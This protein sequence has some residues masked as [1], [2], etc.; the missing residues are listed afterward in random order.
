MPSGGCL[1]L[2]AVW[3]LLEWQ[4]SKLRKAEALDVDEALWACSFL[5]RSG[6]EGSEGWSRC[7]VSFQ[8]LLVTEHPSPAFSCGT[9]QEGFSW[10]APT[11]SA[12]LSGRLA[13]GIALAAC[14]AEA[15]K[16][17]QCSKAPCRTLV[18]WIKA[19]ELSR[20]SRTW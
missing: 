14:L 7:G 3:L 2:S 13:K 18:R 12:G 19:D 20:P 9:C 4:I 1:L 10:R 11:I 15:V 8:D 5:E 17:F 16:N 6:P